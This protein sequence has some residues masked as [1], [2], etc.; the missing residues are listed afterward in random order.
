MV[1]VETLVSAAAEKAALAIDIFNPQAIVTMVSGGRDSAATHALAVELGLPV[2]LSIHGRTGC[3]IQQTTDWVQANYGTDAPLIVADAGDAYEKYVLRKG[4]FGKG[5]DAH[6]FAYRVLKAQP[7]RKAV[8][9]NLRN[10]KRG[11]RVMLLNGARKSESENR[12]KHLRR[13]RPD[14]AQQGNVWFNLIHD[15]TAEDRDAY[16]ASRNVPINPVAQQLCRSG[17]CM[18]GTMQT[19]GERL[20]AA[21]LYPEWNKWLTDLETEARRLHGWGWGEMMPKPTDKN[22]GELFMPMCVDCGGQDAA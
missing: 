3:G 13:A 9:A 19:H 2:T 4:F 15:W 17:E 16:L 8:S 10:G 20:E 22:Q 5:I 14:P 11:V 18:C 6:A 1:D 21:A 7:F 12:R